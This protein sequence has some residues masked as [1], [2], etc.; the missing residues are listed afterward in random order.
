MPDQWIAA[1][2][3]NDLPPGVVI[4]SVCGG[5]D[6]VVWRSASGKV[7][8]WNDRCQHRG[9]RLSHGFVRGETLSCIYHG[10]VYGEGGACKSIPAHPDLI[11]PE[12]IRAVAFSCV[13]SQ[14]LVWVAPAEVKTL[15]PEVGDLIPVRSIAL[16]GNIASV[17]QLLSESFTLRDD[18]SLRGHAALAGNELALALMFQTLTDGR[19][20]LHCLM[21]KTEDQAQLRDVSR[22][23]ENLRRDVER[24]KA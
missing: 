7:S 8:A 11:P 2:L 20:K 16:E 14:N 4:P 15:P 10:W 1:C 18:G 23:L 13:E 21:E 19:L 12:A 9:M 22:W 5:T 3:S 17:Q 6:I 24:T